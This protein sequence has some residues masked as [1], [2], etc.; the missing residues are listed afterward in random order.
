MLGG[1]HAGTGLAG[2]TDRRI[3][4]SD[5]V[6]GERRPRVERV[7]CNSCCLLGSHE[8]GCTKPKQQ[9]LAATDYCFSTNGRTTFS[10]PGVGVGPGVNVRVGVRVTVRVGVSVVDAVGVGVGV[11]VAAGT[12]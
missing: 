8:P 5:V 2:T 6:L 7:T 11:A 1:R 4:V 9:S 12:L 10:E 3:R